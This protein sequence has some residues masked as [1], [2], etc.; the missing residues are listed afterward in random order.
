MRRWARWS[1]CCLIKES[2]SSVTL[3]ALLPPAFASSASDPLLLATDL[4]VVEA[5][6]LAALLALAAA[7]GDAW[8]FARPAP[9][10]G[11]R[12]GGG[13]GGGACSL[14]TG[15]SSK[16]TSG[17]GK[18]SRE[19]LRR[20]PCHGPRVAM[21]WTSRSGCGGWCDGL[22]SPWSHPVMV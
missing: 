5:D 18:S 8:A 7:F 3:M 6:P 15:C 12:H 19:L 13:K 10:L 21:G 11:G 4:D 1:F 16:T 14:S 17:D 2:M 9:A 20:R 22:P